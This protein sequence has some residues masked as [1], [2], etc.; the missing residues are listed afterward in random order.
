MKFN[1]LKNVCLI[2]VLGGKMIG[3]KEEL[4]KKLKKVESAPFLFVG[5]GVS[6]RY[7]NLESWEELLRKFSE[8]A[9]G[10]HSN[11]NFIKMR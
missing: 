6:R 7:L 2:E 5:S 8:E 1:N 11:M 3:I 4:S 10:I 9:R